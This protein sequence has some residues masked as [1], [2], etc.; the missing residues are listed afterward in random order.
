MAN[1]RVVTI[2]LP[3]LKYSGID[4]PFM[5]EAWIVKIDLEL[6]A[7]KGELRRAD[8]GD[9]HV[10]EAFGLADAD[11]EI[12]ARAAPAPP[13]KFFLSPLVMPSVKTTMPDCRRAVA[14]AWFAAIPTVACRDLA[15]SNRQ[16]CAVAI[17]SRPVPRRI[18]LRS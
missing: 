9:A 14:R 18:S 5:P 6:A 13:S 10:G 11:G 1:V 17:G 3:R 2:F 16:G 15:A 4:L 8:L 12:P 7:A